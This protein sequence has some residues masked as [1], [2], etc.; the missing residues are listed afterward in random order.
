MTNNIPG[1]LP[2]F[3]ER[4][5]P[6]QKGLVERDRNKNFNAIDLFAEQLKILADLLVAIRV[7]VRP[8]FDPTFQPKISI[9]TPELID[10]K[11][12]TRMYQYVVVNPSSQLLRV[13]FGEGGNVNLPYRYDIP[14]NR[15]FV[16]PVSF[17]SRLSFE[18]AAAPTPQALAFVYAY[19]RIL[20][21]PG[22]Y[23]L[24]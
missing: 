16:S 11:Y 9:I 12:E 15:V 18:Y 17:F 6:P 23:S 2:S 8:E 5:K 3:T 10:V 14:V 20:H 7:N 13:G 1:N 22:M 4:F 21:T 24:V 19:N